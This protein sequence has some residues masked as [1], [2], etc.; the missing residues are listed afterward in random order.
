MSENTT[1]PLWLDLKIDYI[2]ENFNKV[3][4]YMYAYSTREKDSFYDTTLSLLEDRIKAL[5][6]EFHAQ[7]LVQDETLSKDKEHMQFIAR[8]LG[9]YLLSADKNSKNYRT[10]FLL[11]VY[12]LS[13]LEPKNISLD[14]MSNAFKFV[15]GTLPTKSILEWS[16]IENFYPDIVAH[17]LNNV[18]AAHVGF[19]KGE[20][21]VMLGTLQLK[22]R[23]LSLAATT[24]TDFSLA[25]AESLSVM[26][27]IITIV[28]TRA[29]RLRQSQQ[30]DIAAIKTFVKEFMASQQRVRPQLKSYKV[31]DIVEVRLIGK[32]GRHMQVETVDMNYQQI[33]GVVKFPQNYMFYNEQDFV[34]AID[35]NNQFDAV[36]LGDGEFEIMTQ[37]MAYIKDD[38]FESG[39]VVKAKAMMVQDNFNFIGWGTET[40]ISLYTARVEGVAFGDC[41]EIKVGQ[42]SY[43]KDGTPNGWISGEFL[44]LID[45]DVNYDAAKHH[46]ASKFPYEDESDSKDVNILSAEFIK[47]MYR[48]L[49]FNQQH[50]IVNP[51]EV[52]RTISVCM[53]LA[54]LVGKERDVMYLEF[55]ADYLE[56]LL[57]FAKSEYNEIELPDYAAEQTTESIVRR[58]NIVSILQAY[59]TKANAEILDRIIDDNEDAFLVKLAILVQS[60]N[61]L[62]DVINSSMQNIIKREIISLLAVDSDGETDLEEENGVYLG[63][64]ND[65]QEFKTSFFHAPQNAKEQRQY[66]NIFKGVCAFLNTTEGGT[67]Y[68]GVNDLGYVQGIDH[69]IEHLQSITYGNY[70]GM[71]GYIRYITDQA[72]KYFDIDVVA[73]IK[74]RPMYDNK[75]VAMDI[76]PYEFGIVKFDDVAYL[77]LYAESVAIGKSAIMRI[78]SRKKISVTKKDSKVEDLSRAIRAQRRVVLHNYQSSNSCKISDRRVEV[79]DFTNNGTSI[80]CYDLDKCAVRLFNIARIGYVE[81]TTTP[82]EHSAEHKAG[83]ID[84]FNMTGSCTYNICLR[85]NLRAKNLLLDEY[86]QAKDYL[87]KESE[88]SWMLCTD[89]YNLAG[90]GRFYIGLANSIEIVDAPAL[91]EYVAQYCAEYLK[92]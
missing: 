66:V 41:A 23:K 82:W 13:V 79:F 1:T 46:R 44:Q 27:D 55:L 92:M 7:P 17:K 91:K 81:V 62:Q 50:C 42:M 39:A 14:F 36:Y 29:D 28:T 73:N 78:E 60:S 63:M 84:I 90:V 26:D 25:T 47:A 87:T 72:K 59:G 64:E 76:M 45:E 88:D 52:Y 61:R 38:V 58:Q 16:D 2:D 56:G 6:Q 51:S 89:V 9:L 24:K 10:A 83:N 71:D 40:G 19:A 43:H 31:G 34:D 68:I 35:I 67:L 74:L 53:M 11:F 32:K 75:V 30:S 70:K 33:T 57:H 77:R 48:N 15:L 22:S 12:S 49:V 21:F 4:H 37:F 5:I 80:W 86:P 8:L 18:I 65:R 20:N 85:L 3:L 54:T 69:D